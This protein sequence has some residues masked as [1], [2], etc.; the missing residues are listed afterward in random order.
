MS[1]A[2]RLRKGLPL[3]RALAHLADGFVVQSVEYHSEYTRLFLSLA[4]NQMSREQSVVY[5]AIW[6][7]ISISA[8]NYFVCGELIF[9]SGMLFMG[10]AFHST[11]KIYSSFSSDGD[12]YY[13]AFGSGLHVIDYFYD[14]HTV[15]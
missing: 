9:F 11:E 13:S 10:N 6:V 5:P 15:G 14:H 12:E 2:A 1:D 4:L 7:V 3:E 8:T